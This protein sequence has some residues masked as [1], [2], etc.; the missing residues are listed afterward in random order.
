MHHV[1]TTALSPVTD[2]AI[3]RTHSE[4]PENPFV[5]PDAL[6]LQGLLVVCFS[7]WCLGESVFVLDVAECSR[8]HLVG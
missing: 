5:L 2:C 6:V 3:W 8:G 7:K 4:L 1:V